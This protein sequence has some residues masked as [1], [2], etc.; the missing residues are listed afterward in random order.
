MSSYKIAFISALSMAAYTNALACGF[1]D[2]QTV[3]QSTFQGLQI[4]PENI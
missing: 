2:F 3:L 4:D 1:S